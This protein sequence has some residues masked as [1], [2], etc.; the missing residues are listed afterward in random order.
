MRGPFAAGQLRSLVERAQPVSPASPLSRV[1]R[2]ASDD[3][4]LAPSVATALAA[5]RR[6]L[7]LL[8]VGTRVPFAV[9]AYADELESLES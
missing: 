7:L 5:P 1:A 3:E 8:A 4:A 2:V 6:R 9:A